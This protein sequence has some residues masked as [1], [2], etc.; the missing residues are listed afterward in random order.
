MSE[1]KMTLLDDER[2]IEN[3]AMCSQ[4]KPL[5]DDKS[6]NEYIV[7]N[8]CKPLRDEI[9]SL[10]AKVAELERDK[11][12]ARRDSTRSHNIVAAFQKETAEARRLIE[13]AYKLI[14]GQ[15]EGDT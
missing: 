13:R 9:E 8:V 2:L 7:L 15:S 11:G 4:H 14:G 6:V 12:A 5:I 1:E 10:R 3:A